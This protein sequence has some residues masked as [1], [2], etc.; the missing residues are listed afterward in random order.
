MITIERV[1]REEMDRRHAAK[2]PKRATVHV[3]KALNTQQVLDLGN[4]V[5]FTFR[6]RAYGVPPLPYRDGLELSDLEAQARSFVGRVTLDT[7]PEYHALVKTIPR[8]LWRLT[9]SVGPLRRVLRAL[10]LLRNPFTKM[11]EAELGELLGFFLRCPTRSRVQFPRAVAPQP[12]R[13]R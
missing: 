12:T 2:R 10:G 1:S 5:F 11:T 3:P 7:L 4:L 9:R 13:T 8:K 6:G